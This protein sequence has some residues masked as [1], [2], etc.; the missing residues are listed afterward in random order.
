ML[1]SEQVIGTGALVRTFT[2]LPVVGGVPMAEVVTPPHHDA[3]ELHLLRDGTTVGTPTPTQ[4]LGLIPAPS[5]T[6]PSGDPTPLRTAAG[7]LPRVPRLRGLD[8]PR[9]PEPGDHQRS[10]R[11]HPHSS[12]EDAEEQASLDRCSTELGY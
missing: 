12:A 3:G 4:P 5:L 8:Q 1:T 9:R 11:P 10:V 6:P 7:R 2:R